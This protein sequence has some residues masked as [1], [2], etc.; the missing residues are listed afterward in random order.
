MRTTSWPSV[1]RWWRVGEDGG[2]SGA[3]QW[4]FP[5][6]TALR[7]SN[8]LRLPKFVTEPWFVCWAW[9]FIER[10]DRGPLPTNKGNT[11]D[12]DGSESVEGDP[13]SVWPVRVEIYPTHTTLFLVPFFLVVNFQLKLA[14]FC[15]ENYQN[16]GIH[17]IKYIY[18]LPFHL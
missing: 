2:D 6:L 15:N 14:G 16:K 17:Y 8:L 4:S 12:Q 5:S 3:R 18:V 9:L 11:P 10:R 7:R 13:D 1:L